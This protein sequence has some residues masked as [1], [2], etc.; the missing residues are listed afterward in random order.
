MVLWNGKQNWQKFHQTHQEEMREDPN[1]QNKKWKVRNNNR[2]HR[3][4]QKKKN[5]RKHYEQLHSN[6][7][8]NLEKWVNF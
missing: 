7:L 8:E 4:Y 3:N 2:Y 5:T 1:T 6:T